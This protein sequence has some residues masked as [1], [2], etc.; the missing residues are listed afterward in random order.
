[1]PDTTN[2]PVS[3]I[4]AAIGGLTYAQMMEF[5]EGL[6]ATDVEAGGSLDNV[7]EWAALLQSW[8]DARLEYDRDQAAEAAETGPNT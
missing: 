4:A 7:P 3:A 5:A 8:S 6:R 1:M 2:D